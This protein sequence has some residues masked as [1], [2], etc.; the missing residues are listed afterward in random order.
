MEVKQGIRLMLIVRERSSYV[1]HFLLTYIRSCECFSQS[2]NEGTKCTYHIL[3]NSEVCEECN[4]HTSSFN[5]Q[6]PFP[7]VLMK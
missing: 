7:F 1:T 4:I 6:L 5:V 3:I 2:I